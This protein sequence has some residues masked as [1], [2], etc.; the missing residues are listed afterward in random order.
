MRAAVYHGQEDVRIEEISTPDAPTGNEVQVDVAA[1]G[2]CGS[3]LH[4]YTAGPIFVPE[5]G[6]PHPVTGEELPIPMGHEF[7][8]EV[9]AI[10]ENVDDVDVGDR[11]AVNPIVYCGEC[12]YCEA[13]MYHLCESGGF[14]G[15]SGG[16]GGLS[17]TVVVSE[18]KAI[19]LPDGVPTEYGALVE[20]FS[21]GFHAVQTSD[22]TAGDSVAVYGTGPIGLTVVQV[23]QA[24][25]AGTIFGIEPQDSR[26]NLAGDVG[27]DETLD[28][29]ETDAVEYITD[30]TSGGVDVAFEAA[31]IGQTVRDAVASTASSGAVTVVSI[32]EDSIELNPNDF[33]LGERSLSGTLAY[34][35]GPR[36]DEDFG[37]V[38]D[39]FESGALDPEALI[40]SRID[41][42]NV[43]EDGFEA[44][45]DSEREE[46]K[47]LVDV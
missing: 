17:E 4:E 40:S 42:E 8:G 46:V 30:Q 14:I 28:P 5:Q 25:G 31:G 23:L 36:S 13:G 41:L 34:K 32:F 21:V 2:I 38:I 47:I 12:Q 9:T 11:V 43:V 45:L 10:G 18:E 26:R 29:T 37:A 6:N 16:G 44:L 15:L 7:A 3:D 39:M 20:P 1:C 19:T 33:V 27:A 24:A 35:G 22:F